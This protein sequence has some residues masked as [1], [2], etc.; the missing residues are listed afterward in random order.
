MPILVIRWPIPI[1]I[2]FQI[3][4]QSEF[5]NFPPRP[6]RSQAGAWERGEIN[7]KAE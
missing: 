4:T 2:N 7:F 3:P 1:C 6:P 5:E